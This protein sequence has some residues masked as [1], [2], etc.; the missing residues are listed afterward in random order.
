MNNLYIII[1]III[2]ITQEIGEKNSGDL[3][4]PHGRLGLVYISFI[5]PGQRQ[6]FPLLPGRLTCPIHSP[7]SIRRKKVRKVEN[8]KP[9]TKRK[10]KSNFST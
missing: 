6:L 1:I 8:F 5:L 10:K 7:N 9:K 2:I 4:D 3:E